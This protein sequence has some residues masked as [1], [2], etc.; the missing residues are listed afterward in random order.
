MSLFWNS[1]ISLIYVVL[2]IEHFYRASRFEERHDVLAFMLFC[3]CDL[4]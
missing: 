2:I 4:T 1:C 3:F